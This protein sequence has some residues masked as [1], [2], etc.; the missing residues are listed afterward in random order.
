MDP[1]PAT[2]A[3]PRRA[4]RSRG[5]R[6]APPPPSPVSVRAPTKLD[7]KRRP[8]TEAPDDCNDMPPGG[9]RSATVTA[10]SGTTD[11]AFTHDPLRWTRTDRDGRAAG[12]APRGLA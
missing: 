3:H 1:A 6:P 2:P 5:M 10:A 12:A 11:L 7:A 8:R 4:A 9:T